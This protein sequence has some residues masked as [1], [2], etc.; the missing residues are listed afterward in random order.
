[1]RGVLREAGILVLTQGTTD[2]QWK[3]RTRFVLAANTREFSRLFVIDYEG[4]G[5]RYNILDIFPGRGPEALKVWS[6]EYPRILLRD[7]Q[8]RSLRAAGFAAVDFYGSFGF[9]P[10]DKEKSRRLVTVAQR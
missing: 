1:M 5:A 10:Y 2:R 3:E 7:D 9:E 4:M 8:E 6:V